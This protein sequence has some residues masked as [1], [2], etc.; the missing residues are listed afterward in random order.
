MSR[1]R[2]SKLDGLE[3]I[4]TMEMRLPSRRGYTVAAL[5]YATKRN[6]WRYGIQVKCRELKPVGG[7][8]RWWVE[9]YAIPVLTSSND[10]G[11][12]TMGGGVG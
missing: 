10:C 5:E 1:K 9:V 12:T 8:S 2:K 4:D 6:P 3:L 7:D 11:I